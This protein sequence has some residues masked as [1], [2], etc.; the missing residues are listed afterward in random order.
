MT[1]KI[2][3][4]EYE[5][6]QYLGDENYTE[7][8]EFITG[9]ED[10]WGCGCGCCGPIEL[11]E[12]SLYVSVGDYICKQDDPENPWFTYDSYFEC[13]RIDMKEAE[14]ERKLQFKEA[15][16]EVLDGKLTEEFSEY[17]NKRLLI[18]AIEEITREYFT[19]QVDDKN[20]IDETK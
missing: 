5:C 14:L 3:G 16:L 7:V 19:E 9:N 17:S 1:K 13:K 2:D 4:I 15:M 10:D 6:I 18:K 20:L 11:I 8:V 12:I